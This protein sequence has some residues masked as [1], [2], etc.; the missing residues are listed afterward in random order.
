MFFLKKLTA[1][2]QR[3]R[4]KINH[5]SLVI[6]TIQDKIRKKYQWTKK[7]LK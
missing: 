1:P 4:K 7:K 2:H 3:K 6:Q 5:Q